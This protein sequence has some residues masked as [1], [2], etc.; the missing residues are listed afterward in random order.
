M[1]EFYQTDSEYLIFRQSI[2][3]QENLNWPNGNG[4]NDQG[5]IGPIDNADE[6]AANKGGWTRSRLVK[7]LS[8]KWLRVGRL[9]RVNYVY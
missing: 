8:G 9:K 5:P 1:H 4:R 6:T 3:V 2:M 7:Q